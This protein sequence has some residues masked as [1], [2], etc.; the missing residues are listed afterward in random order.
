MVRRVVLQCHS[1]MMT[2]VICSTLLTM[3]PLS[4]STQYGIHNT[5]MCN[6]FT[7]NYSMSSKNNSLRYLYTPSTTNSQITVPPFYPNKAAIGVI[8][9][10]YFNHIHSPHTFIIFYYEQFVSTYII[11]NRDFLPTVNL[12]AYSIV[13]D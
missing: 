3:L 5:I 12:Y 13:L 1:V 10:P 8:K 9:S 4:Y 11:H 2:V 6:I 7:P